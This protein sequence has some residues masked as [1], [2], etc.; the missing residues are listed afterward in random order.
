MHGLFRRL[1]IAL[2]ALSFGASGVAARHCM[3]AH[4]SPA[5]V[6]SGAAEQEHR[7]HHAA[8]DAPARHC[9]EAAGHHRK[10]VDPDPAA[11]DDIDCAKCCGSCTLATAVMPGAAGHSLLTVS[12]ALY[13][14]QSDLWSDAPLRVD[15]GIPK[16]IA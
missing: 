7:T 10:P 2:L 1:L 13:P 11:A 12:P 14:G 9:D 4:Q 3:A 16:R 8:Q 6:Q 5:A 15:P